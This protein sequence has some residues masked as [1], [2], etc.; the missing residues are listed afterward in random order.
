[1]HIW[2]LFSLFFINAKNIF[3]Y[4][5]FDSKKKLTENSGQD[6]FMAMRTQNKVSSLE[7]TNENYFQSDFSLSVQCA[8][9]TNLQ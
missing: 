3:S 8:Y 4:I 6:L 7:L 1:M 5:K 9:V 2:I